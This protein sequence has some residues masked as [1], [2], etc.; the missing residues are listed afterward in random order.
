MTANSTPNAAPARR[1]RITAATL[2]VAAGALAAGAFG[3]AA[4]ANADAGGQW[5][6]I[7]YSPD[8]GIHGWANNRNTYQEALDAAMFNCRGFGG[9][10]CTLGAFSHNQ[11]AAV[12]ADIGN[13]WSKWAGRA[14]ADLQGAEG[15]AVYENGGG[16]IVLSRCATGDQ[17]TG[18]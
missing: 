3:P 8:N 5:V 18:T 2:L 17:G 4:P 11:C 14:G 12:A 15:A 1:R 7:A 9:G 16:Q 6:V 10:Q 13:D